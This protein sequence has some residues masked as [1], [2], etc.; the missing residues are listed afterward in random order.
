MPKGLETVG[1]G[2]VGTVEKFGLPSRPLGAEGSTGV[3]IGV[4]PGPIMRPE[5]LEEAIVVK[6]GTV[7]DE[8]A[9]SCVVVGVDEAV[10]DDSP[11]GCGLAC[12]TMGGPS[13]TTGLNCGSVVDVESG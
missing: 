8:E 9:Q 10:V 7:M 12:G 11:F 6:A 5:S 3:D 4:L 2:G 13:L 1:C